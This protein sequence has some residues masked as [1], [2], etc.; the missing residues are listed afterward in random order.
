[1]WLEMLRLKALK[2]ADVKPVPQVV[3]REDGGPVAAPVKTA[4][5]NNRTVK[6]SEKGMEWIDYVFIV[7]TSVLFC[8]ISFGALYYYLG[9]L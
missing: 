7:Y 5:D 9:Y 6:I 3:V 8:L 1:M 4:P 2:N